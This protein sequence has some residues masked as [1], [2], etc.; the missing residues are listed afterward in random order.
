MRN[1][2]VA[3]PVPPL[4]IVLPLPNTPS[5]TKPIFSLEDPVLRAPHRRRRSSTFAAIKNWALAVQPGS[6]AP[7][8]PHSSIS[9]S[10]GL[11]SRRSSI[12][13]ARDFASGLKRIKSLGMLKRNRRKSVSAMATEPREAAS[14]L[15]SHT[16]SKSA[17]ASA[18]KKSSTHPPLPPTLASELL[19]RQF[20]DGGSLERHAKRVMEEQAR[21]AAPAGFRKG[22]VLPVGTLY[23]DEKGMLWQDEDEW[24]E[25]EAL[26][27]PGTPD[28]PAREWITFNT[29]GNVNLSPVLP[30]MALGV[31]VGSESEERRGSLAS[32]T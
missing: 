16:R 12:S 22:N 11:K 29:T 25:R 14:R 27:S 18:Q 4:N 2:S 21:E 13:A 32:V 17:L 20:T 8:S 9:I 7:I 31:S 10:P 26:L 23:R 15:R 19:L 24:L 28:S 5:P 6:P 3:L 1:T 30:G